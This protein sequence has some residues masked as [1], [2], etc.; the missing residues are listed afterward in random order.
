[1]VAAVLLALCLLLRWMY[2]ERRSAKRRRQAGYGLLVE[3]ATVPS[4]TAADM[5]TTRL[6]DAGI[7]VT[8]AEIPDRPALRVL[9]FPDD[10]RRALALLLD[11]SQWPQQ[12]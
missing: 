3:V 12:P 2:G 11:D 7:R 1:M 9:V 4:P 5:V 6:R 8:T 10:Q